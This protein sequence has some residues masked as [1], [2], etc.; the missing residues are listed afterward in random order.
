[1]DQ[2][3]S[4]LFAVVRFFFQRTNFFFF[5]FFFF[6][7]YIINSVKISFLGLSKLEFGVYL[8]IIKMVQNAQNEICIKIFDKH[9]RFIRFTITSR[10]SSV[11]RTLN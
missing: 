3:I 11:L 7:R 6:A 10:H 2:R 4:G 1:M 5:F 9:N 8:K